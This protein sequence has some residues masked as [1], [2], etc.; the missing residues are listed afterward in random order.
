[1]KKNATNIQESFQTVYC[2]PTV[3][4]GFLDS[5]IFAVADE[6]CKGWARRSAR[7]WTWTGTGTTT[8]RWG[9]PAQPRPL[10]SGGYREL[11]KV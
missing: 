9:R 4:G 3:L 8:L 5:L 6:I 11:L 2:R 1:M 7:A 10:S